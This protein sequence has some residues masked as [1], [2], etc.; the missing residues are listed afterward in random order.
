MARTGIAGSSPVPR[1]QPLAV[2]AKLPFPLQME[3]LR[4][5]LPPDSAGGVVAGEHHSFRYSETGEAYVC[6]YNFQGQLGLG[7]NQN[8][9]HWQRVPVPGVVQEV[10]ACHSHSFLRL[11]TGEVYGC[12]SNFQDQ[13]GLGDSE[14]RSTSCEWQRVPVPGLVRKVVTGGPHSFLWLATGEVYACGTNTNGQLG[15]GNSQVQHTWQRVPLPGVVRDI[16]TGDS[17][18]LLLL[19]TGEVYACGG[20]FWGQLGLGD[21]RDR[22]AS[23]EWQRI[24]VPGIVREIAPGQNHSLLLLETGEVYACGANNKGQLGLVGRSGQVT[25]QLTTI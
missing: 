12:G 3:E 11:K 21:T 18:S 7:D 10:A 14:D 24:P 17:H 15:L 20:N 22:N 2:V 6:G 5:W 19:A 4:Q 13:L 9:N 25:W 23:C 16:V 1:A 8:R